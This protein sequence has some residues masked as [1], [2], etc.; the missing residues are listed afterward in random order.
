MFSSYVALP[1]KQMGWT[2]TQLSESKGR[3]IN[4][5]IRKWHFTDR[6]RQPEDGLRMTV[7]KYWAVVDSGALEMALCLSLFRA[8]RGSHSDAN[9][10]AWCISLVPAAKGSLCHVVAGPVS[11]CWWNQ[12]MNT[13]RLVFSRR[14]WVVGQICTE[15]QLTKRNAL[16]TSGSPVGRRS[17]TWLIY[18]KSHPG[19]PVHLNK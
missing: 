18:F 19:N 9:I 6:S 15:T 16:K 13:D 12:Q 8:G 10:V 5:K 7:G 4:V 11:P 14:S 17:Y 1:Y 2:Q 3:I